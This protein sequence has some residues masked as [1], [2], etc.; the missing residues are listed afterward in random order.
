M[1]SYSFI[2]K[3][4]KKYNFDDKYNDRFFNKNSRNK[5]VVFSNYY[6]VDGEYAYFTNANSRY[7]TFDELKEITGYEFNPV[8]N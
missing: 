6:L 3:D 8:K 4:R 5:D 2:G 1:N 7:L